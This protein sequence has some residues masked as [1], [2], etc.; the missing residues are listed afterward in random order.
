M[1]SSTIFATALAFAASAFAQTDGYAVMSAPAE[2]QKVPAGKVFTV[3]WTAGSFKGPATI[4]LM[5]GESQKTLELGADIASDVEVATG[6]Y[7]WKVD[8]ALGADKI[9]G[10]KITSA[11]DPNTFQYSF[12]FQV[13]GPACDSASSSTSVYPITSSTASAT[14]SSSASATSSSTS[15]ST[16]S[17]SSSAVSS[18]IASTSTFAS[19]TLPANGTVSATY[20]PTTIATSATANSTSPS[21]SATSSPST[22]PT[23]GAAKTVGSLAFAGVAALAAFAL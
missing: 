5:K 2:G 18:T 6:S 12:P 10:L 3:K 16:S 1:R 17:S 23:A 4:T 20:V 13:T 22:V 9:Y 7:E 11:A 15:T 21:T 19:V 8:C 14:A